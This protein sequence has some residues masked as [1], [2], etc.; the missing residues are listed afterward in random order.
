MRYALI[1]CEVLYRE[2]CHEIA[3]SPHSVDL[4]RLPKGLH[5]LGSAPMLE[6]LQAAVDLIDPNVYD[7]ILMGYALCNNGVEGL[8]ARSVPIVLPRAHDCITLFLGSRERYA[9][10]FAA[11]PGVYF[12]TTGWLERGKDAGELSQLSVQTKTG[13]N[14]SYEELVRKYGEENAK[15]LYETLGDST[16]NYQQC[17]FIAMGV[18]Q[19]DRFEA[20]ARQEAA[21]H[22]WRFERVA[23]DMRLIRALVQGPPWDDGDFLVLPPGHRVTASYDETIIR[24]VPAYPGA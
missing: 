1:A 11:N 23:G 5:D 3:L 19:D 14:C 9:S 18:G 21:D 8:T 17:T 4:N 20:E 2:L 13:M 7:G 6:R 22:G 10:Y 12:E 24:A 15:Y 16:R